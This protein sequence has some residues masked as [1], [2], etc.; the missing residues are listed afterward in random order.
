MEKVNFESE[1]SEALNSVYADCFRIGHSAYKFV[2]DFG[3]FAPDGKEKCF[4]TRVITG[5]DTAKMLAE[6]V[7]RSIKDYEH[8]FGKILQSDE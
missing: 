3:Q 1:N 4:H 7:G 2:L 8:Q 5:P 6:T